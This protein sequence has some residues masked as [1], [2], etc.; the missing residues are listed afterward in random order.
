MMILPRVNIPLEVN[1]TSRVKNDHPDK[2][3]SRQGWSYC[4]SHHLPVNTDCL[5]PEEVMCK[6]NDKYILRCD[7][8]SLKDGE[9]L[10]DKVG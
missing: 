10:N 9:W 4:Q 6:V 3:P 2:S 8:S 5:D 1:T 7:F